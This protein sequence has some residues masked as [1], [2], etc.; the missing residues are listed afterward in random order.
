MKTAVLPLVAMMSVMTLS[1]CDGDDGSNGQDGS[2]GIN[3]QSSLL[4][5]NELLTG[6]AQ[7][8]FGGQQ[9]ETGLDVN[10]NGILD[11]DE[12]DSSQTQIM[13]H[14][15]QGALSAELVGRYQSGIFGQSAAEIVDYHTQS[16]LVFVVNA[17]SGQVDAL[18]ISVL[19]TEGDNTVMTADDIAATNLDNLTKVFSI[20]VATD[21][22]ITGLGN[23]N[24]ISIYDDLLAVAVERAD[25]LGNATQGNGVIAFY[26]LSATGEASYIKAVTV[27]A[28]PDN[29]VFSH[30]GALVIVANEGEPNSDYSVDPQG[31]VAVITIADN[32]PADSATIIDFND[33]DAGGTRHDE[34]SE[35]IKLNGPGASVS[36]DLEPEYIAVS[37]DNKYAYVSLQENNAIAVINLTDNTVEQINALGLKHY[38]DVGN[39]IDASDKDDAINIQAYEG[40]YGMYQ[41]DTIVSYQWNEQTFVVSANEGD[42][43]DYDGFSEEAR[44][45]DLLL[46]ANHP[47]V[48][49]AQDKTQLGRLKVT[50]TMGDDDGDGDMDRIVSYGARSF[51][52]WTHD[53]QLVFDSGSQFE[54]ITAAILADNFNNHNEE[55]KGDSRSDDKGPEPEALAIGQIAGKQY[56]FI[57]L[58]RTSGFMIYDISNPFDVRFVDYVVNRDFDIEFEIDGSDISGQPELAGDLGPEGMKFVSPENSPNGLPLLIVGNEVSGTTSVYQ[59]SFAQ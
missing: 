33:F 23:V 21:A 27:G 52:I 1:G 34:M 58:E 50:T 18:D 3:G 55:S 36:Q 59:L 48:A 53:G 13:C 46:D 35:L 22:E 39:E 49:A 17:H 43:R 56:A 45:E 14:E 7:C 41:P 6:H 31:S 9:I 20:D 54:R 2:N 38:G 29:L 40:V 51:S 42:A 28:L 10:G 8:P 25:E 16:R 5:A 19:S 4:L 30:D 57:G 47:Q 37:L 24:S 12:I 11:I 32:S 15:Q 26:R 44:A